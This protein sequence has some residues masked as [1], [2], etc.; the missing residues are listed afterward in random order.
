MKNKGNTNALSVTIIVFLFAIV[1]CFILFT[2]LDD[3]NVFKNEAPESGEYT[4]KFVVKKDDKINISLDKKLYL[5]DTRE[6]FGIV[7][8]VTYNEKNEMIVTIESKGFYENDIF[9]LNGKTELTKGSNL[10]IMN[11]KVSVQITNIY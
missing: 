6:Y 8:G 7:R 5:Y 10:F 1:I 2:L 11:N 9:M 4:I 3:L